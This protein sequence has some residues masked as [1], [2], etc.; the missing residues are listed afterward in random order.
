MQVGAEFHMQNSVPFHACFTSSGLVVKDKIHC[1]SERHNTKSQ[2]TQNPST[3]GIDIILCFQLGLKM[4][5]EN[6]RL[7]SSCWM[8]IHHEKLYVYCKSSDSNFKLR[9]NSGIRYMAEICRAETWFRALLI[10]P[11]TFYVLIYSSDTLLIPRC[12]KPKWNCHGL[13]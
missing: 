2:C 10:S 3:L 11:C 13:P 1:A 6:D 12:V 5:V 4:L 9:T 7:L 8:T